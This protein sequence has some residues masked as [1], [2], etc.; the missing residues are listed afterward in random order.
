MPIG[1]NAK[2]VDSYLFDTN[3]G[4]ELPHTIHGDMDIIEI[5]T[6]DTPLFD[7]YNQGHWGPPDTY[8]AYC[9]I[10][11]NYVGKIRFPKNSTINLYGH[12]NA[13]AILQPD[14]VT[15]YQ[16]QPL[17]H[18]NESGPI[19]A[20]A[21]FFEYGQN[22]SILGEGIRGA[23]GGSGLSSIG[24]TIRKGEL[25]G[26]DIHSI[27]HALKLEF[28]A[29]V[30]YYGQYDYSCYRWPAHNCDS[31]VHKNNSNLE[32]N[33]TNSWF[34]PGA[35]LAVP[36]DVQLNLT[37]IPGQKMFWALQNFGGYIVDDTASNR[38]SMCIEYGVKPEFEEYWGYEFE[39]TEG[40]WYEDVVKVFQQLK[41]V[42]NNNVTTIGGGGEPLQ[43]LAPP[44]CAV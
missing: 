41:I 33:G 13:A 35:L 37:T 31:Y 42:I 39:A 34:M 30:Y 17:Y 44:I 4:N 19:L 20:Q 28:F 5:V 32:Y 14:N 2:F 24:G 7:W 29:N 15:I 22:V 40:N 8:E 23:H 12:N 25:I 16:M 21:A 1:S 38:C 11:G 9:T 3:K 36:S 27:K 6:N 10:T 18:C 43:P 26:N